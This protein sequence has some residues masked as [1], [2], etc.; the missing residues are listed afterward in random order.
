MRPQESVVSAM[1]G[2]YK[3]YSHFLPYIFQDIWEIGVDPNVIISVIR[4]E[5][6][7]FLDLKILDLGLRERSS[8]H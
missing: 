3:N 1:D 4:K 5:H 8:V 6:D 7:N 2:T